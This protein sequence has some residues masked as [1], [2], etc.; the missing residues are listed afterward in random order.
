MFRGDRTNRRLGGV[1][2]IL[3]RLVRISEATRSM[4]K[5]INTRLVAVSAISTFVILFVIEIGMG[6]F[7]YL[8]R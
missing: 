6:A 8:T 7:L 2:R 5:I 4:K 1:V 3:A